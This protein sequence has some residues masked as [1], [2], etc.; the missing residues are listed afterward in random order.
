MLLKQS[1]KNTK[2]STPNSTNS[3]YLCPIKKNMNE[4]TKISSNSSF[5]APYSL[6]A[7][8]TLLYFT[9]DVLSATDYYPFGMQ[10]TGR[11]FIGV[12][13]KYGFNSQE[14]V[15]EIKGAGNHYTALFWEYDSRTGIRWNLDPKPDPWESPYVAFANNPI[16]H[17]D[18]HGDTEDERKKAV[19]KAKEWKD[20]STGT[21]TSHGGKGTQPGEAVD[22][23]GLVSSCVQAAGLPDPNQGSSNGVTNIVNN[24]TQVG[25]NDIEE[26]YVVTFNDNKHVG[27]ISGNIRRDENGNVISFSVIGSQSSTGPAEFTV[28]TDMNREWKNGNNGYWSPKLGAA[29]KWDTPDGDKPALN[30]TNSAA[31]EQ[32]S[33]AVNGAVMANGQHYVVPSTQGPQQQFFRQAPPPTLSRQ[34]KDSRVPIVNDLGA[35]LEYFGF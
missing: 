1:N 10:M 20:K 3:P 29:Y 6:Q 31:N 32:R 5:T 35:F 9:A 24:S 17:S 12:N 22:C 16:Y 4:T 14:K 28:Q 19:E 26:G 15:D 11:S 33:A 8:D 13:Y 27:I 34:L 30:T 7:I 23:S 18:I 21:A 25:F 2:K